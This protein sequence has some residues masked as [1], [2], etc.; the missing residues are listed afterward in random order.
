M[1]D[2]D[3]ALRLLLL[4]TQGFGLPTAPVGNARLERLLVRL[5]RLGR[6]EAAMANHPEPSACDLHVAEGLITCGWKAAYM[7]VVKAAKEEK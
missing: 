6:I 7:D 2:D 4:V 3:N 1:I 5:D